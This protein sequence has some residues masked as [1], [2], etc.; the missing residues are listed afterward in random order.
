MT[1]SQFAN[2]GGIGVALSTFYPIVSTTGYSQTETDVQITCRTAGGFRNL[3]V[4]CDVAATGSDSSIFM[5]KN[6]ANTSLTVVFSVS[7]TG[8]K[9]DTVTSHLVAVAATDEVCY[10]SPTGDATFS[11]SAIGTMFVPNTTTNVE[12]I[13]GVRGP[14][15]TTGSQA[16]TCM[17]GEMV[18]T[19]DE[20]STKFSASQTLVASALF[21]NLSANSSGKDPDVFGTRVNGVDG[22]LIVSYSSGQTGFKED[23]THTDSISI[24]DDFNFY[25]TSDF[26]SMITAELQ[27]CHLIKSSVTNTFFPLM[28]SSSD[29]VAVNFNTTTYAGVAGD[30]IFNTTEINV[31]IRPRFTFTASALGTYVTANSIATSA[32]A[33]HV[34]DAGANSTVTVSYNAAQTGIKTD[35]THTTSI[36][37]GADRVNYRVATPNTSGSITFTYIGLLSKAEGISNNLFVKQA[38][39][40]ASFF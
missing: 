26:K 24:G 19:S 32:T 21:V 28:A 10:S 6:L 40:R 17:N 31:G 20:A 3:Y 30:L 2:V 39:K 11:S 29:G 5:R 12:V 18:Q 16:F 8:I 35:N 23:T 4:Y 13:V 22:T 9:E 36:A 7:Q 37:T 14:I 25:Q 34:R 33:V 1:S 27:S 15:Q 38:I